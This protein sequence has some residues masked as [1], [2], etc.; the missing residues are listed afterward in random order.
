LKKIKERNT[1]NV[2]LDEETNAEVRMLLV[3][4]FFFIENKVVTYLARCDFMNAAKDISQC[5]SLL[6]NYQDILYPYRFNIH[7]LIGIYAS[8][9]GELQISLDHLNYVTETNHQHSPRKKIKTWASLFSMTAKLATHKPPKHVISSVFDQLLEIS[10]KDDTNDYS[11]EATKLFIRTILC[12]R[13]NARDDALKYLDECQKMLDSTFH[14]KQIDAQCRYVMGLIF[15]KMDAPAK[16]IDSLESSLS[17]CNDMNDLMGQF[18]AMIAVTQTGEE[19][20]RKQAEEQRENVFDLD[21]EKKN[22]T[23]EDGDI[24]MIFTPVTASQPPSSQ[25]SEEYKLRD[26]KRKLLERINSAKQLAEHTTIVKVSDNSS[27]ETH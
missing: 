4:K 23:D 22:D 17:L 25:G 13:N 3:F 24:P 12:T 15:R 18:H 14:N 19:L 20:R 1:S 26:L 27:F 10:K 8:M 9:I 7:L 5:I 11:I 6:Y 16:A 2:R 21:D